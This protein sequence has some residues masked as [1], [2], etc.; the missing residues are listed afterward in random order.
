MTIDVQQALLE[1]FQAAAA[2]MTPAQN[3]I[4]PVLQA[5][6]EMKGMEGATLDYEILVNAPTHATVTTNIGGANLKDGLRIEFKENGFIVTSLHGKDKG[7]YMK[8]EGGIAGIAKEA[9][10]SG[11]VMKPTP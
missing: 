2:E 4:Q 10:L 9:I 11:R 3:S 5:L 8:P 7:S 1:G 6:A